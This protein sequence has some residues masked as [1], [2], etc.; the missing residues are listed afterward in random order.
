MWL[1]WKD[2]RE[3]LHKVFGSLP[4]KHRGERH[5]F[6]ILRGHLVSVQINREDKLLVPDF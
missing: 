4:M 2:T 1:G 3:A 5:Y 6:F